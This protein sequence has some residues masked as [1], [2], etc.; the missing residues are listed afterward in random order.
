MRDGAAAQYGSDAIAGVMNFQLKDARAGGSVELNIGM[1]QAGDGESTQFD[2]NV[3][4]P[5]GAT[6]FA[7]LSL[8][9]GNA[10]PTDRAAPRR[11]AMALIAAGNTHVPSDHPQVWGDPTVDNDLKA[12]GNF[13]YTLPA[14]VQAYAHTSYATRSEVA[15]IPWT[16]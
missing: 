14:G 5:L 8:E 3:G 1:Y 9:Y 12:F 4:L 2:G 7:N 13:G 11:D 10:N 16:G 6:G 15:P